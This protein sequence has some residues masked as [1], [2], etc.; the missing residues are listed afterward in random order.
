MGLDRRVTLAE[1]LDA[2]GKVSAP[3]RDDLEP[4][5]NVID[6]DAELAK[7]EAEAVRIESVH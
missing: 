2:A 7:I 1:L 6:I 5:P 4:Q 3:P